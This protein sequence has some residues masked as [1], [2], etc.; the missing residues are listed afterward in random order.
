MTTQ[1]H[2]FVLYTAHDYALEVTP[3]LW[4]TQGWTYAEIEHMLAGDS[5]RA[6]ALMATWIRLEL[7]PEDFA[8]DIT[9]SRYPKI[10]WNAL[11][12]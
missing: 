6:D 11:Y 7:W 10:L 8:C 4:L 2:P 12:K 5:E 9:H 3:D 1:S